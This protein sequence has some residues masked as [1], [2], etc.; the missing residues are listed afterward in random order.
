M[1]SNQQPTNTESSASL[2]ITP[3]AVTE[4][5]RLMAQESEPSLFLR[6]GISSG[7]CSGMSYQMA[8]DNNPNENDETLDFDGLQVRV[9][10]RALPYL[11]GTQVDYST[12]MLGGGFK[13]S[14]P[15]AKRSC[16]CGSSFSC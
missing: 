8:F 6:I 13:F 14:N 4:I 16:G 11:E 3:A 12:G 10:K 2:A 15:N 5:K 1:H 7:G 9:D